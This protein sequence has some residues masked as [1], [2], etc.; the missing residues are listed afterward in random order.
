MNYNQSPL[1]CMTCTHLHTHTHTHAQ[2][3]LYTHTHIDK[4]L[5]TLDINERGREMWGRGRGLGRERKSNYIAYFQLMCYFTW[6]QCVYDNSMNTNLLQGQFR[7]NWK[8]R[9]FVLKEKNPLLYY[10]R[11]SKVSKL[12]L[13]IICSQN[14]RSEFSIKAKSCGRVVAT[15]QLAHCQYWL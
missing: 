12:W 10:F 2:C 15:H 7:H 14:R 13:K 3:H 6:Y 9:K 4:P 1:M 5:S 8:A 11:G